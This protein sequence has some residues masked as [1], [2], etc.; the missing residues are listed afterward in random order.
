MNRHIL[1][2][3]DSGVVKEIIQPDLGKEYGYLR[4][5]KV[6]ELTHAAGVTITSGNV[7]WVYCSGKT[8][9][10]D[11]ASSASERDSI[12][13]GDDIYEQTRQVC[14]NLQRVLAAVGATL[15]DVV[16][17]RVYVVAPLTPD[18]FILIHDARSEFFS[19]DHYPA[20]TLVV[21]SG[22]ARPQALIE[23]DADAVV[24]S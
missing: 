4:D 19:R 18:K 9:T 12:V 14:R 13:G 7:R 2:D 20:S 5:S 1:G 11:G 23:I 6:G 15:D 17:V 3:P 10:D 8:A 16:R 22:L 21:V 24:V